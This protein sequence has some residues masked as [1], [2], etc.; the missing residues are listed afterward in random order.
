MNESK[1]TTRKPTPGSRNLAAN[2]EEIVRICLPSLGDTYLY[3]LNNQ[4]FVKVCRYIMA[5]AVVI[6]K[7]F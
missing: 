4:F 6:S 1:A 7:S 3:I 2:S 5:V